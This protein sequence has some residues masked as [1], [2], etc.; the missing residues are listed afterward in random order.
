[1]EGFRQTGVRLSNW[2]RWG[3]DDERGTLNFVEPAHV[4]AAAALVRQG[5][6][7]ELSIPLQSD[8]P[9]P[10][11]YNRINPVHLM[12]I[13][14]A[15][16]DTPM[17]TADDW[18]ITP[19]QAATQWDSLAHIGYDDRLYNDVPTS[20]ITALGGASRNAIDKLLP[21]VVGRG[22]LLDIAR[23]RGIEWLDG[24][25]AIEPDEL[26]AAERRHGTRLGR[27]DI[28]AVRTGW[29]RK[30]QTEGWAEWT[31]TEPGLTAACAEWIH[32]REL[33][34]VVSDNWGIE[35]MPNGDPDVMLPLHCVLIRD[36]GVT[37]GEIFN[38]EELAADVEADGVAE[39]LF[40]APPL[41]VPT[42]VGS[43]VSPI[44]V[45]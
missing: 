10:G 33:A 1:M 41:R 42:G 28:L 35:V 40:C 9:Q 38:L 19:L 25:D 18:L 16:I 43:V 11:A 4:V 39:F 22:V 5:K 45:K 12:S 3:E 32:E 34:A 27:G 14:P 44:A 36:M 7:F 20:S 24:G 6:V 15:D 26:E 37:L 29:L 30:G 2:G 23:L 8:G 17:Q 31:A 13:L 21:G